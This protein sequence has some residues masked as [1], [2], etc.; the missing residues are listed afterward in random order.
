MIG[1]PMT[2]TAF[3]QWIISL[4]VMLGM[5]LLVLFLLREE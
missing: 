4:V 1:E 3:A 5:L 2:W